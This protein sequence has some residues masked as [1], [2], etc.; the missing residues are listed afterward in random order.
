M[1]MI[2][3]EYLYPWAWYYLAKKYVSDIEKNVQ[4]KNCEKLLE[5]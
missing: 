5:K 2:M 4:K 1:L 3:F